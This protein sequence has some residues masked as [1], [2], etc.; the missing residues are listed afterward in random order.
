MLNKN[1]NSNLI[2]LREK[3]NWS[4]RQIATAVGVSH[5]AVS[6]WLS[7]KAKPRQK[8]VNKLDLLIKEFNIG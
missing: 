6:K 8:H 3:L 1:I 2:Y 7:G 4:V 5:P